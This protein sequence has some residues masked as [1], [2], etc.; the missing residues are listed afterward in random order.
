MTTTTVLK[1]EEEEETKK[2]SGNSG[3]I[4]CYLGC[5]PCATSVNEK[6]KDAQLNDK[7]HT[8]TERCGL[9]E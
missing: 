6:R 7:L 8:G 3:G 2:K 4:C 5:F 1:K 9:N